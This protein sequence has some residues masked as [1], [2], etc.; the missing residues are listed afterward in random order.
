[1][2]ILRNSQMKKSCQIKNGSHNFKLEYQKQELKKLMKKKMN[3]EHHVF[4]IID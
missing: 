4:K 1:M 2:L 3:N